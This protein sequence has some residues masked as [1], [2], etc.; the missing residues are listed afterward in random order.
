MKRKYRRISGVMVLAIVLVLLHLAA[1][2]A[3]MTVIVG[4]TLKPVTPAP[5]A[6]PEPTPQPV[7]RNSIIF[8][9]TLKPTVKPN[10]NGGII[11]GPTLKP[12]MPVQQEDSGF[13]RRALMIYMIGSNLESESKC[14]SR[15]LT[16]MLDQMPDTRASDIF[17]CAGG[18]EKWWNKDA[19]GDLGS[20]EVACY[21]LSETG[22]IR[23]TEPRNISMGQPDTLSNFL[24]YCV[25]NS[26]ADMFDLILWDHGGGPLGG[27]GVDYAHGREGFSMAELVSALDNSPFRTRKLEFLGFDACLMGSIEVAAVMAPY[28]QYM[29]AS[30]DVFTGEG[31]DYGVFGGDT[32]AK[33]P[34]REL[35]E[36]IVCETIRCY[37]VYSK[38]EIL[39]VYDLSKVSGVIG[40]LNGIF[41]QPDIRPES[42]ALQR[43]V[44][45]VI[46]MNRNN[47][48]V[49][50]LYDLAGFANAIEG[51]LPKEAGALKSAL[52]QLIIINE[53]NEL[54]QGLNGCS[55]YFPMRGGS[56]NKSYQI[57][58]YHW[59]ADK[60]SLTQYDH[61]LSG[62]A[63][64]LGQSTGSALPAMV[65][66]ALGSSR[67]NGQAP[68]AVPQQNVITANAVTVSD[69]GIY[70]E[71]PLQSWLLNTFVRSYYT[72]LA[73]ESADTYRLVEE[74]HGLELSNGCLSVMLK[75]GVRMIRSGEDQP[76]Q[77]LPVTES[78]RFSGQIHYNA[79]LLRRRSQVQ[80]MTGQ[81]SVTAANPGGI[82][83]SL[84]PVT[85]DPMP[86]A[87]FD[88]PQPGDCLTPVYQVKR[89]TLDETGAPLP[90]AFWKNAGTGKA[91]GTEFEV[92]E[93]GVQVAQLPCPEG[94]KFFV[95]LCVVDVHNTTYAT[96]L[97][98]LN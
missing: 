60:T 64:L 77:V 18:S 98:P 75:E 59:I 85:E 73:Q 55:F 29:I 5:T 21:R 6:V 46:Y 23:M 35:L 58:R 13:K 27:F 1:A 81:I 14:A 17:L 88:E 95:Q 45:S 80:L 91:Y 78:I 8:G 42:V 15:E 70:Y 47:E 22:F 62:Y 53:K 96:G 72:I 31:W 9:P 89:L 67:T 43:R 74:G 56:E 11:F 86:T 54:A 40:A 51:D 37:E 90:F 2:Q 26:R 16:E 82:L 65:T 71:I 63:Q 28:A 7:E 12:A 48:D 61:Y 41:A 39:S 30:E 68:S 20:G 44:D 19:V 84:S 25:S 4:P 36:K 52:E 92:T 33:L 10:T 49:F 57:S 83:N 79:S 69:G 50:D 93:A 66:M 38:A 3:E 34:T 24:K 97:A 76:W 32:L 94:T 87:V